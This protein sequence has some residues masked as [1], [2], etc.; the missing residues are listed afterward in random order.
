MPRAWRSARIPPSPQSRGVVASYVA[1]LALLSTHQADAA[2]QREWELFQVPGGIGFFLGFNVVA[3]A[4]LL[5]GLVE[6]SRSSA[7]AGVFVLILS[8]T[9]LF[10]VCIHATFLGLGHPEFRSVPSL[11]VLGAV[12]AVS[13][14]QLVLKQRAS[15]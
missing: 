7:R 13:V 8:G 12:F 1:N 10:T 11:L 15:R 4:L 5:F 3:L 6:V 9:G 14:M 2:F